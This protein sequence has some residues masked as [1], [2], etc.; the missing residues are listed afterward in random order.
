METPV[1]FANTRAHHLDINNS[2][3]KKLTAK[4]VDE[5]PAFCQRWISRKEIQ[6]A[7]M[8]QVFFCFPEKAGMASGNIVLK[9]QHVIHFAVVFKTSFFLL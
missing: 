2:M 3:I 1:P 5:I 8:C 6:S 4:T 7:K 9:K